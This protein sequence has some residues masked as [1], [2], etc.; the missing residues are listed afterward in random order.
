MTLTVP[1]W[2]VCQARADALTQNYS[3]PPIPVIEIAENNGVDV[4]F[5]DFGKHTDKV[6]GFCDFAAAKLYVNKADQIERQMFTIA[7]EFGHWTLH[8]EFYLE[9]PEKYPVF[10][11][12]QSVNSTDPFEKEANSFAAC[13][14]V[15]ERLLRPVQNAPVSALAQVFK[16]SRTM[17]EYRLK[18]VR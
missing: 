15:P 9:N 8:R 12:F 1:R 17:M 13:L 18:N 2:S 14:L 11:R 10:P 7:H 16:V 4:V 6:A 3:S 5:A